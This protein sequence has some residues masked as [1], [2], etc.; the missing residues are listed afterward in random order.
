METLMH[1][2]LDITGAGYEHGFTCLY[3]LETAY[4][5]CTV[6]DYNTGLNR[7]FLNNF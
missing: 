6:K 4:Y 7:T 2:T 1:N 5:P 3:N